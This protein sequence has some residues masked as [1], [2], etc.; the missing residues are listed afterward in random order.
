M[1][2]S[3]VKKLPPQKKRKKRKKKKSIS[4]DPCSHKCRLLQRCTSTGSERSFHAW[5]RSGEH[6]HKTTNN[7]LKL[8]VVALVQDPL[9]PSHFAA[10]S[11]TPCCTITAALETQ[12]KLDLRTCQVPAPG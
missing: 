8:F 9:P 7:I 4:I 1:A 5:Q 11:V 12:C 2:V 3:I 6:F 10:V